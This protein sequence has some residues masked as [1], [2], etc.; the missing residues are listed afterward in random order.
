[1]GD[2]VVA[3]M[4]LRSVAAVASWVADADVVRAVLTAPFV[5]A[6]ADAMGVLGSVWDALN[7]VT[8]VWAAAAVATRVAW[9][10]VGSAVGSTPVWSARTVA[11]GVEVGV[12]DANLTV[13]GF[14]AMTAT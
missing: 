8:C 10:G 4:R 11:V 3:V 1:M 6:N 9:A 13:A 2:A 5:V 14:G 12:L 7:A